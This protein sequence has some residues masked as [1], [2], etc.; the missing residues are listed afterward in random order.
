MQVIRRE[1]ER[2]MAQKKIVSNISIPLSHKDKIITSATELFSGK[3]YAET[4]IDDIASL[5]RMSKETF[6]AHF[7]NKEELFMECADKVFHDMYREVWQKIR[8]EKDV[9]KRASIRTSAFFA[10]YPKWIIMMNLVRGLSVG[11]PVIKEKLKKL[12]NQMITPIVKEY[13]TFNR[14]GNYARNIDGTM[15]GYFVMGM[16][17]YGALLISRGLSTEKEVIDYMNRIVAHGV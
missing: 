6:Y 1:V 4:S 2:K 13:E 8:D 10:S 9:S 15:Y 7:R 5:A 16:A 12:L 14:D 11:N 3:G 17:E